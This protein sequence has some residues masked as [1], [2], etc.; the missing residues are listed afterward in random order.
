MRLSIVIPHHND[1]PRLRRLLKSIPLEQDGIEVIVV[2]DH[3]TRDYDP[4]ALTQSFPQVRFLSN[5]RGKPG[6]GAA[7]NTGLEQASGD[8][9]LFADSDD[10][11]LPGAFEL[12]AEY[13][14]HPAEVVFFSPCSQDESD[15]QFE[16]LRDRTQ[17]YRRIVHNFCQSGEELAIRL[18]FFVPWS[19]LI[20][21]SLIQR[22]Q[23]RFDEVI[24]GNDLLF[25]LQVGL[26][27]KQISATERSLYCVTRNG[28]SLTTQTDWPRLE[29]RLG[30]TIRY[31][32]LLRQHGLAEQQHSLLGFVV[33]ARKLGWRKGLQAVQ[34]IARSDNRFL[35]KSPWAYLSQIPHYLARIRYLSRM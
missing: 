6:A 35:V 7:R 21:H 1:E 32:D 29:S 18:R 16:H 3:S 4:A 9:L 24:A 26:Y 31:N 22:H 33:R 28:G 12:L 8:W 34:I 23:I 25:S 10:Y 30:A 13:R 5:D 20:R 15:G 17:N 27:A 11:F 2:D 14:D 19:K